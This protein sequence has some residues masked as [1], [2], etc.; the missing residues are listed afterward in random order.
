MAAKY[1]ESISSGSSENEDT[2]SCESISIADFIG[3]KF[4]TLAAY[5]LFKSEVEE[6]LDELNLS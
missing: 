5:E 2:R 4:E 3:I 6:F 1:V